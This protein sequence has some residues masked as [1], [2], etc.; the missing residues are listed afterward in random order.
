MTGQEEGSA[1]LAVIM[2][3]SYK[4]AGALFV[5]KIARKLHWVVTTAEVAL[6]P[7]PAVLANFVTPLIWRAGEASPSV[8]ASQEVL[9]V[10]RKRRSG[11]ARQRSE[12]QD[13]AGRTTSP[14]AEPRQD[15]RM[16]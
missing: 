3:L 14:V 15:R 5:R 12:S 16:H 8:I 2:S 13:S 4:R 6:H 10:E 9:N 1:R 7:L 11:D